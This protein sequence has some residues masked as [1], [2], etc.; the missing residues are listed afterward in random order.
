MIAPDTATVEPSAPVYKVTLYMTHRQWSELS[1]WSA[2]K[3][4]PGQSDENAP[5][6]LLFHDVDMRDEY[7]ARLKDLA[8]LDAHMRVHGTMVYETNSQ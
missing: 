6:L 8:D 4:R 2:P 5:W 3:V 1:A 7:R